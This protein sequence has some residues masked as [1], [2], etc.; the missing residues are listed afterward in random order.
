M[1]VT[2][3]APEADPL[4]RPGGVQKPTAS[5]TSARKPVTWRWLQGSPSSPAAGL[6]VVLADW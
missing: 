4:C 2:G 6:I 5:E 1:K 3:A